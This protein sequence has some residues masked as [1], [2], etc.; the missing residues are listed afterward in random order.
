[1]GTV[2]Y[3]VTIGL[4]L[5][6]LGYQLHKNP[7]TMAIGT[8]GVFIVL[9]VILLCQHW[10]NLSPVRRHLLWVGGYSLA[11]FM[12]VI[13]MLSLA[14]YSWKKSRRLLVPS[15]IGGYLISLVLLAPWSLWRLAA[16][17]LMFYFVWQFSRF[18]ISSVAYGLV[19]RPPKTGPLVVLG[20]GLADGYYVGRI[21]DARIR[22]A[23]LD[24]KKMPSLPVIVFSGGQGEDQRRSEAAA[25][26]E[27]AVLHYGI[28]LA[29][30]RLEDQSRNTIQN[31]QYS[32]ALLDGQP[33]TFYTSDYHVFRGALIAQNLGI[34]ARG[35]G[36]VSVWRHRI[37]AFLREF[38]G[39][40]SLHKRRQI[41]FGSLWLIAA[42]INVIFFS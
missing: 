13:L 37:P 6:A 4:L 27:R 30:T 36:G 34:A 11:V 12:G 15:V 41:L 17:W 24:A 18:L 16:P 22:A 3:L 7:A 9:S 19:S 33:L 31:L 38:A 20:G 28:P 1:M 39:V 2:I 26:R 29:Q 25:M 5:V 21:V 14:W 8:Y 40:M 42:G 35:R 32:A 10:L 23:V